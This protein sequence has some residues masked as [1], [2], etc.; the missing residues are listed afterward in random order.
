M[1]TLNIFLSL[2]IMLIVFS[3]NEAD[4][5]GPIITMT[6]DETV[7]HV[8][9]EIYIDQGAEAVDETDGNVTNNI[10]VDNQVDENLI[11]E[12]T[13]TYNVIDEAGNE[14]NPAVRTVIVYNQGDVY[15][16]NYNLTE[17][18]IPPDQET[19]TND[20]FTWVDSSWNYRITFDKFTCMAGI[21]VFADI[22]DTLVIMPFQLYEDSLIS[23]SVQGSGFINDSIVFIEYQLKHD[24]STE[25]WEAEFLKLE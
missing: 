23:L 16:G 24:N 3:C 10:Y 17:I 5:V 9:N 2:I 22:Y 20:V 25:Y 8:L 6:G 4:N 15:N 14:A 12:Y 11:G 7:Q 18:K 21:K 1:K 19:C 13:V